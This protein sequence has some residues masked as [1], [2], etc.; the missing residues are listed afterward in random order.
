MELSSWELALSPTSANIEDD[1]PFPKVGYGWYGFVPWRVTYYVSYQL[2]FF[3]FSIHTMAEFYPQFP[4]SDDQPVV[5]RKK[6][7]Y[8][9]WWCRSGIDL[10]GKYLSTLIK[11]SSYSDRKHHQKPQKV[12]FW[13]GNRQQNQGNPGWWNRVVDIFQGSEVGEFLFD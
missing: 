10:N 3:V 2:V 5:A 12:A 1:F 4:H 9:L 11:Y 6:T 8:G 7:A 13:K